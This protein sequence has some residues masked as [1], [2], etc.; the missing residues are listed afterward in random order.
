[1]ARRRR[2]KRGLD[3]PA[4]KRRQARDWEAPGS[5]TKGPRITVNC[6]CGQT[7]RASDEDDLVAKVEAHVESDHVLGF[8]RVG[9]H[10]QMPCELLGS[11]LVHR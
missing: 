8:F 5:V 9:D 3:K 10:S 7:V 2:R 11:S 4:R 6:E 1:M